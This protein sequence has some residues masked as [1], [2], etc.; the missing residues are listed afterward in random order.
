MSLLKLRDPAQARAALRQKLANNR[1]VNPA[2]F[3][4][5]A[6]TFSVA[7]ARSR[8]CLRQATSLGVGIRILGR[9]PVIR[10]AGTLT[11]GNDVKLE[12]P[13]RPIFFHVFGGA[14]LT[15]GEQVAVNEG[16]R[17]ECTRAIRVGDRVRIGFG[18]VLIDNHFHDVYDRESRPPGR[19]IVVENDVWIGARAMVL[20]GVR[21]GEGSIVGAGAIVS[22]D[23]PPF[24]VVAGNP[25]HVVRSLS[26]E[27]L[28]RPA[29]ASPNGA[30]RAR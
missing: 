11:L 6:V 29:H 18:A 16:A 4:A 2:E 7:T 12:A 21:I 23:V 30:G 8:Y 28:K 14:E 3:V 10:N 24:T 19:S 25:A 5:R 9:P 27:L 13:I 22:N 1:G 15:L 20:P 26:A 17:F